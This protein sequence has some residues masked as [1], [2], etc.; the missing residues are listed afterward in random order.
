MAQ[1][2]PILTGW[3][4]MCHIVKGQLWQGLPMWQ[5]TQPLIGRPSVIWRPCMSAWWKNGHPKHAWLHMA[6]A[7]FRASW[8]ICLGNPFISWWWG[9]VTINQMHKS[10]HQSLN[11]WDVSCDPASTC[12][13]S[14]W[15]LRLHPSHG[16]F[17]VSNDE[18]TWMTE[19]VQASG[20]PINLKNL[21][22]PQQTFE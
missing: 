2:L 1:N 7:I 12:I 15:S 19:S 14:Q 20:I 16:L 22:W 3:S 9:A 8:H 18:M 4:H 17:S 5:A 10:S 13:S 21:L 6:N 11:H